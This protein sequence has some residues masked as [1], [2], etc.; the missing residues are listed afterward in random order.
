MK[1]ILG[2]SPMF[3]FHK[4]DASGSILPENYLIEA[5]TQ[6]QAAIQ[7]LRYNFKESGNR[8][9]LKFIKKYYTNIVESIPSNDPAFYKLEEQD[10]LKPFEASWWESSNTQVTLEEIFDLGIKY[11]SINKDKV[12]K[13]VLKGI[14]S[15]ILW[16]FPITPI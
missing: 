7:V 9:L 15:I 3:V 8:H 14:P 10:G 1:T 13:T 6:K 16:V 5:A 11:K 12:L 2:I 4:E